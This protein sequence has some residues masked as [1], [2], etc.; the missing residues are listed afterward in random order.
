MRKGSV[1][2][3]AMLAW[4]AGGAPALAIDYGGWNARASIDS[5]YD[6]N[7]TRGLAVSADTLANG[8][9]DLGLHLGASVGN[10]WLLTPDLDTWLI[11]DVHG[12]YGLFYPSLSGT[13]GSL[14]SN[15]VWHLGGGRET[16]LMLGTSAFWG[17]GNY[18]A[19]SL[20]FKQPLAAG[21]S[22]H[23]E[24]G[25]STYQTNVAGA[26]FWMPSAGGGL[27]WALPTGTLLGLRYAFQPRFYE[28]DS[29]PRH[30]ALVRASQRLG[31]WELHASVLETLDTTA[32]AG[33]QEGYFGCGVAYDL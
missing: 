4:T 14:V 15:T 29:A 8:S 17:N 24:G 32:G 9:Q 25:A 23:L 28:A 18:H 20:D 26:S 16:S 30:Q 12:S 1:L 6:D 22:A 10:V 2:L 7:L 33:F 31:A 27:D 21:A 3:A 5:W 11:V 13:W 19:A